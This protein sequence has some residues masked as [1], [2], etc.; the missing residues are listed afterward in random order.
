MSIV[1]TAPIGNVGSHVVRALLAAGERP[2]LIA[3]SP[4]KV[5]HFVDQGA[6][7]RQGSHQDADFLVQ[8][9]RDAEALFVLTPNDYQVQDIRAHYESFARAAVAAVQANRIPRV[10]HLS[11]I[12]ADLE[13]GNGPVTGLHAAEAVLDAA[14]V[15][16]LVHLR[17]AYFMENTLMQV[18]SVLQADSL[19]TPLPQGASFPMI[20]TRDIGERAADLLMGRHWTGSPV[21]ELLGPRDYSYEDVAAVL[22]EVLGRSIR[23]V[24]VPDEALVQSLLGMG[25]SQVLADAFV[26]LTDGLAIG[27]VRSLEGR[28]DAN[29]TPTS[30]EWFAANVFAAALDEP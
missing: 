7:V 21:M 22:S 14:G 16:Q 12:G 27:R 17:P 9:T 28:S 29:T 26:E 23:H 5:Q 11:S 25:A 1:V 24:N 19:F 6:E 8:A 3:R 15:E 2:V 13:T 30:Y 10:V 18:P 20:A 4:E